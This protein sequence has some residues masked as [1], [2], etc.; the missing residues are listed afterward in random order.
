MTGPDAGAP[1]RGSEV[2][3]PCQRWGRRLERRRPLGT[4]TLAAVHIGLTTDAPSVDQAGNPGPHPAVGAAQA[5]GTTAPASDPFADRG[6]ICTRTPEAAS[7]HRERHAHER[8]SARSPQADRGCESGDR[9]GGR[10]GGMSVFIVVGEDQSS[11]HPAVVGDDLRAGHH[12][13]PEHEHHAGQEDAEW[14]RSL[15]LRS[16]WRFSLQVARLRSQ[17]GRLPTGRP[18]PPG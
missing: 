16:L 11:R 13:R 8:Q 3:P 18:V 6:R 10:L 4:K 5:A 9:R 14:W 7:G 2:E 15:V 17:P 1:D 12:H